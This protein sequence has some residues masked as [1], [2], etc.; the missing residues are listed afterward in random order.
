[1][2][3]LT[4]KKCVPCEGGIPPLV[5]GEIEKNLSE[6]KEWH[7]IDNH[8]IEKETTFPDFKS[9]LSFV[10]KVGELAE[11]ENHHPNICFTWGKVEITIFTHKINGL[12]EN[13]FI[14]AAKIDELI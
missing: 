14:L 7:A 8:H 12:H 13:D 6:I 1:M 3:S 5:E 4:K 9:A 10:N 11:R 2:S